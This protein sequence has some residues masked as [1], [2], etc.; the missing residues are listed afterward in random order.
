MNRSYL[1]AVV[2]Y[3]GNFPT[4]QMDM[5]SRLNTLASLDVRVRVS[6]VKRGVERTPYCLV[7][8]ELSSKSS[9]AVEEFKVLLRRINDDAWL[10]WKIVDRPRTLAINN[11]YCLN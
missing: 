1:F 4:A 8:F 3:Q 10:I 7:A 11:V 9:R 2:S 6:Q 5:E